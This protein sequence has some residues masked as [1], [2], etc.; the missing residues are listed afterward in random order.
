MTRE[1]NERLAVVEQQIADVCKDVAELRE[2]VRGMDKKLD[3]VL[4]LKA[5]KSALDA[6]ERRRV[7]ATA[8]VSKQIDWLRTL[9]IGLLTSSVL[10][11][12]TTVIALLR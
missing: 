1:E 6:L 4:N 2:D 5:D 10:L 3:A 12:A 11:L 9:V 7:D 8:D